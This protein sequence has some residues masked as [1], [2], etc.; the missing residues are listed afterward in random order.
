M[1]SGWWNLIWLLLLLNLFVPYVQ[2]RWLLARRFAIIRALE[3]KR[4]SRVITLIHRQETISLFGIPITRYLD[5]EDSE[6]VLEAIHLTPAEMPIDIILHTPGGLVLA[7][8]QVA[9]ALSRH[10][11]KVTVF[12]PHYAMSGGT[13]VA[14][15]SDEIILNR[16]AVLGS[17][18]PAL[19]TP[20][21]GSYPAV[22]IL[23]ALETPNPNREDQT[24]ILGDVAHK[25]IKQVY[26]LVY[27]LLLKRWSKD[28]AA[29]IAGALTEGRWTHDH[30]LFY[31]HIEEM[32]LPVSDKMPV[33]IYELMKLY[34]QYGQRRP[35]VEYVGVPYVPPRRPK[36]VQR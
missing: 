6:Q 19:G 3:K 15:A 10:A 34:P 9:V 16:D 20:Q 24:L 11:G 21:A 31:E 4:S 28:K 2:R 27:R 35:T 13:I 23:K 32:G 1:N 22:S 7:A 12:V 25:A 14:L 17:V 30:P 26:D 8:E 18:D 29:E 5:M 33:E 36:E